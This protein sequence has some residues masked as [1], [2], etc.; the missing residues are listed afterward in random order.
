VIGFLRRDKGDERG[1]VTSIGHGFDDLF[2][3]GGEWDELLARSSANTVFLLS[4]WLRAW[5]ETLGCRGEILVPQ[6][7]SAGRLVAAAA[8]R[9]HDG[10]L[11][12]AGQGP[13]DY[14]DVLVANDLD[15]ALRLR[16]AQ[17]LLSSARRAARGLE[18][19]RLVHV[20]VDTSL[21][22]SAVFARESGYFATEEKRIPAPA[23]DMAC[24]EERLQKKSLKRHEKD[25]Q[26]KGQLAVV[27]HHR[28]DEILPQLDEFFDQHE[29]RW[30]GTEWPSL[31]RDPAQREFYRRCTRLL[32]DPGV[33][34]FTTVR[35]D[36]A[37]VASHYGF[38]Y[39]GR[40]TWY[41]P[42][43]DPAWSKHSPGEVL[44][45]RLL[46]LARDEGAGEFDFTVGDEAF[47]LRFATKTREVTNLHVTASPLRASL[48]RAKLH[49]GHAAEKLL[50]KERWQKLL[51]RVRARMGIVP[52]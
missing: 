20:P 16:L 51:R 27:T 19:F 34:R 4:G 50:G 25:L 17:Q 10:V 3:P 52:R 32:S 40:F 22:P 14:A 48:R 33:L 37:L 23:M 47:K 26:R 30:E 8:F 36:G 42:T 41:K 38:H 12:L 21:L 43:Y 1:F 15:D 7:R 24:V 35:L 28:A 46:E 31:F 18:W 5:R 9:S 11:E 29:R 2:A 45:K 39:A 49:A 6:I 44:L 13:S